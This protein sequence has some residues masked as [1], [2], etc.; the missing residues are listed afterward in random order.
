MERSNKKSPLSK[1]PPGRV[2]SLS[3]RFFG[4]KRNCSKPPPLTD[5]VREY[6]TIVI[7]NK[8]KNH[9]A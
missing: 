4:E 8:T 2:S 5:Q 6:Q 7:R 1:L 9:T 3:G